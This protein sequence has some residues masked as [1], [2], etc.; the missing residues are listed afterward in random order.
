MVSKHVG[1]GKAQAHD[2]AVG[3]IG[4][5]VGEDDHCN[6]PWAR[7]GGRGCWRRRLVVEAY[8]EGG[9]AVLP[10]ACL[11]LLSSPTRPLEWSQWNKQTSSVPPEHQSSCCK[12]ARCQSKLFQL[13]RHAAPQ[14]V[15]N[16]GAGGKVRGSLDGHRLGCGPPP[17]RGRWLVVDAEGGVDRIWLDVDAH[18]LD[19]GLGLVAERVV[20]D[21]VHCVGW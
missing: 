4:N 13:T 5:G 11:I 3:F 9:T 18:V 6:R 8:G 2:R 15:L 20:V 14:E 1:G 7:E 17:H 12:Q 19:C 10:R 16:H 21:V